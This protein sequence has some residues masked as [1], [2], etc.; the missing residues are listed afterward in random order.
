MASI[1]VIK[2]DFPFAETIKSFNQ[3][4]K[5]DQAGRFQSGLRQEPCSC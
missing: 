5:K 4:K 2:K 3:R 1:S